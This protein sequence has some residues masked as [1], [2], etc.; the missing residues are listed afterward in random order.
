MAFRAFIAVELPALPPV[1]DLLRELKG[2]SRALKT[3]SPDHLHLTLKFLGDTEEG[4]VP[5]L[6]EVIREACRGTGPCT[7]RVRGAGAF[8]SLSRMSVVWLGV[9]GAEPLARIAKALDGALV[10][11][12]FPSEKRPWTAHLTLAR[13]KGGQGLGL[14]RDALEARADRVFGEVRLDEVRLKK[15]V[16]APSG[17]AYTTVG[18]VRLEG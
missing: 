9:E 3:V 13:V 6:L 1:A 15:S 12:G 14:V 8:P 17:P 4:L 5:E 7:V 18:A 2:A 11:F 16:L 10:D